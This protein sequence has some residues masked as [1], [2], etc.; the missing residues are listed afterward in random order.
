MLQAP[1]NV[2]GKWSSVEIRD[3]RRQGVDGIATT[4]PHRKQYILHCTT[5]CIIVPLNESQ[6]HQTGVLPSLY[7]RPPNEGVIPG[8]LSLTAIHWPMHAW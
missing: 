1:M 5:L 4:E 2:S 7:W 3:G 6:Y 8:V